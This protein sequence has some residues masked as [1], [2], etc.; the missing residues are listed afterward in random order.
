MC[1][2]LISFE[3]MSLETLTQLSIGNL[4][5]LY[6]LVIDDVTTILPIHLQHRIDMFINHNPSIN[7]IIMKLK[8]KVLYPIVVTTSVI[9]T[10]SLGIR[11]YNYYNSQVTTNTNNSINDSN[12]NDH[13]N[14]DNNNNNNRYQQIMRSNVFITNLMQSV[15]NRSEL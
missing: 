9:T 11:V 2:K 12:N 8:N 3:N 7:N 13:D 10:A 5:L 4:F 6:S 14:N 1:Y 15:S